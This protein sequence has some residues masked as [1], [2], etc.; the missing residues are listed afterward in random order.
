[1]SDFIYDYGEQLRA[2]A[3]R[4]L[5]TRRRR[6]LTARGRP[7]RRLVVALAALVVAAPAVAATHPWRPLLGDGVTPGPTASNAPAPAAQ[8][9]VLSVLRREQQPADRGAQ[10]RYALRFLGSSV[11]DVRTTEI[12]LLHVEPDGRGTVLIPVGRYG[13]PPSGGHP[14]GQ[15]LVQ[16]RPAGSDGLCVFAA[17]ADHGHLAGGASA[18]YSTKELLAGRAIAGLGNRIYGLVPDGVAKIEVTRSDRTAITANVEQNFFIYSGNLGS[19]D[20]RWLDE[21][22]AV[23][24]TFPR[25]AHLGPP[26]KRPP[27]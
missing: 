21:G 25:E 15:Q 8:R 27:G 3:W 20:V 12:R 26:P 2:A 6:L 7:T 5:S 17:D 4:R 14:A 18:C 10:T 16:R 1:M 24:K 9:G 19:G 22:G 11:R 23:I 13:L